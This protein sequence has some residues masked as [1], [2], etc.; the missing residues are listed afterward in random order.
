MCVMWIEN[1]VVYE[2]H[3]CNNIDNILWGWSFC[4][5]L[6]KIGAWYRLCREVGFIL[7]DPTLYG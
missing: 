5:C 7:L 1:Y 4:C 6:L 3:I 2:C